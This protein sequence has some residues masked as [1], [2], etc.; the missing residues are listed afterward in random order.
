MATDGPDPKPCD[1]EIY[2]NGRLVAVAY[3][4]SN[5]MENWVKSVAKKASARVDWHYAGG[6]AQILHLGDGA[7]FERAQAAVKELEP[8]LVKNGGGLLA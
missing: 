7:S 1:Q 2:N 3:G 4:S 6:R 8:E 5:M